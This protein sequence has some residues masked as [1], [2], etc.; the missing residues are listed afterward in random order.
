MAQV[1]K[2]QNEVVVQSATASKLATKNEKAVE[3]V[4]NGTKFLVKVN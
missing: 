3:V 4:R 2:D 1:K